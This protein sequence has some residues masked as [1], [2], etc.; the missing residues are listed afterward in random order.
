MGSGGAER[1]ISLLSKWFCSRYEVSVINFSSETPFYEFDEKVKHIS[2]N[3][4]TIGGTFSLLNNFIRLTKLYRT[5]R[6]EKP[7][8]A[9][10]FITPTNI[11][12]IITCKFAKIPLIVSERSNILFPTHLFWR[13]MRRLL[14]KQAQKVVLLS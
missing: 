9:I 11:L 2:L 6:K 8:V 12:S 13:I 4:G 3:C 7:D 14:Y 5:L 10:S 1:I